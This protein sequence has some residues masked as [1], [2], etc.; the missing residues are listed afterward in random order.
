MNTPTGLNIN[1]LILALVGFATPVIADS[2]NWTS[3]EGLFNLRIPD[4]WQLIPPEEVKVHAQSRA[5]LATRPAE[6]QHL[7]IS[8]GCSVF[9]LDHVAPAPIRQSAAN[10]VIAAWTEQSLTSQAQ[11][12][13]KT[14]ISVFKYSNLK[15]N[16]VQVASL[17]YGTKLRGVPGLFSQSQFMLAKGGADVSFYTASCFLPFGSQP[18]EEDKMK[19]F[20]LSLAFTSKINF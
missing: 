20:L 11:Q 14:V 6:S 2:K 4:G 19:A 10:S 15:V 12:T 7:E 16:D 3:P 8:L 9:K 13:G 5:I 17:D 18:E 1:L